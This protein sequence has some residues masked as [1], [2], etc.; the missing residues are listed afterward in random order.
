VAAN[1]QAW[2]REHPEPHSDFDLQIVRKQIEEMVKRPNQLVDPGYYRVWKLDARGVKERVGNNPLYVRAK[3]Y[4]PDNRPLNALVGTWRFGPYNTPR[5]E[6]VVPMVPETFLEFTVPADAIDDEGNLTINFIN[7]N[8]TAMVFLLNDGLE[9]LY[10]EAGFEVNFLR[11]LLVIWCWLGLMASIGLAAGS[12]LS[13]PVAAFF[14][15]G[16][17]IVMMFSGTLSSAVEEGTVMGRN[18]ETGKVEEPLTDQIMIPVFKGL[19]AV[20]N[21][22]QAFSPVDALSGGRSITWPMVGTAFAQIVLL[23]GGAFGAFGALAF[24]RRE[25]ASTHGTG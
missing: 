23:L 13:F 11:G 3:C 18:H 17:L 16:M 7:A 22:V 8:H 6:R 25:L 10:R 5:L 21:L 19:L 9:V 24:T 15:L 14:S 12:F 4:L 20:V 2:R 1:F